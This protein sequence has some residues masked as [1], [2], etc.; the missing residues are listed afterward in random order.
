VITDHSGLSP[1]ER[2]FT[3]F[4]RMRAGEGPS[5]LLF[6]LHAFLLLFAYYLVKALREAFML[7]EFDAVV[8]SYAVAI[9]AVVLMVLVP[10]YSA[11]RRHFDG[12]G[13]IRVI[14]LFFALNLLIF[15]ALAATGTP[16]GF[17]FFVWVSIFGVMVV[18]Q[19]WGFAADT[20]NLKTGQRL[21]P[22]IMVG[23]NLGALVGAQ[24]AHLAVAALSP[25]GLMFV[26][27]LLLLITMFLSPPAR[28]LVP[29]GSRPV[30]EPPGAHAGRLLGGLSLVLSDPYL[31]LLAL[32]AILLNWIN[33]TGEYLLADV[34]QR[35]VD[36]LVSAAAGALDRATLIAAI[37]G[38][39]QFW[40]TLV[41]LLIQIFLVARIYRYV[42]VRGALLVLPVVAFIGYGFIAFVPVFAIIQFV[43][44]ADNSLDYSLMQT[45]RHALFLPVNRDSKYDGKTAIDTFFWR[46]GDLIQAGAVFV[47]VNW[48]GFGT[49]EFAVLNMALALAWLYVA[50]VIGRRFEHLGRINVINVAPEVGRPLPDAWWQPGETFHYPVPLDAFVDAD[51]GDVLE[52]D[53]RLPGGAP[54]PGWLSFDKR[55][56]AVLGKPPDEFLEEILIEIVASDVDGCEA[57]ATFML[58]RMRR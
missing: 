36:E 14:T 30:G 57:R 18:A 8:R 11:V 34:V 40:F 10:V 29:E 45:T 1:V 26:A 33:T 47:G 46:F 6:F 38:N 37:Y 53:A 41:G 5:V 48:L 51:P 39:F 44:I 15:C 43:K 55:R 4:T 23:G 20:F 27:T 9:I 54:L 32:M 21:F 7:T 42:G 49:V 56:C 58:R 24:T 19:F 52:L 28:R 35:H 2:V 17:V 31:R 12:I 13:L 50:I 22:P 16:F 25:A 3:L